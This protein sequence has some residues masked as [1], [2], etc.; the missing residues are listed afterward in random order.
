ML[1]AH[2]I[3]LLQAASARRPMRSKQPR[4]ARPSAVHISSV[5]S[6]PLSSSLPLP[7]LPP[8]P[9]S[10]PLLHVHP[11]PHS[12]IPRANHE[13][14]PRPRTPLARAG[15]SHAPA[16]P[17]DCEPDRARSRARPGV[18]GPPAARDGVTGAER[19]RRGVACGAGGGAN[20]GR[21]RDL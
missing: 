9:L 10:L 20:R 17:C 18:Y 4:C 8:S 12:P 15:R 13:R 11:R 3:Q 21:F 14:R 5:S 6:F 19:G 16:D 7:S 1:G 2:H